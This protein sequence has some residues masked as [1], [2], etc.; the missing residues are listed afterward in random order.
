MS[1]KQ[2]MLTL[3]MFGWK[4]L[5]ANLSQKCGENKW[6]EKSFDRK[7]ESLGEVVKNREAELQ[8]RLVFRLLGDLS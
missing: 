6:E 8:L 3:E 2:E 5:R 7:S 4:L 1:H